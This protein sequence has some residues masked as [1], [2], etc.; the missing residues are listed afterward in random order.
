LE[1]GF[2]LNVPVG[3]FAGTYSTNLDV[4]DSNPEEVHKL[5]VETLVYSPYDIKIGAYNEKYDLYMTETTKY[6]TPGNSVIY[7][8]KVTNNGDYKDTASLHLYT[9]IF[10]KHESDGSTKTVFKLPS[11]S[12]SMMEDA[13]KSGEGVRWY[14]KSVQ[15][16]PGSFLTEP[17]IVDFSSDIDVEYT[18]EIRYHPTSSSDY[19]THVSLK[20]DPDQSAWVQ[21]KVD[22]PTDGVLDPIFFAVDVDSSGE[23]IRPNN[24]RVNMTLGCKYSDLAFDTTVGNK[25]L[26]ITGEK[27]DANPQLNFNAAIRNIGEIDATNIEVALYID[28]QFFDNRTVKK[29]VKSSPTDFEDIIIS[30]HWKPIQGSH[31][32]E[33]RIDPDNRI[34]ESNEENNVVSDS[35][36]IKHETVLDDISDEKEGGD[37]NLLFLILIIAIIIVI[38][39]TLIL[40]KRKKAVKEEMSTDLP[41][42]AQEQLGKTEVTSPEIIAPPVIAV[43]K[44]PK[45]PPSGVQQVESAAVET[46]QLN[47]PSIPKPVAALKPAPTPVP[48]TVPVPAAATD[49]PKQPTSSEQKIPTPVPVSVQQGAVAGDTTQPKPQVKPAQLDRDTSE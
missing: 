35:V 2:E 45:H 40:I 27:S 33:I 39:I 10:H 28:D 16:S 26:E 34:I 11:D 46:D 15:S 3:T 21:V 9:Y 6:I 19:A 7:D 22:Y 20:L 14:I 29:L 12:D 48:G 8:L 4:S 13:K 5:I 43:G 36:F 17:K 23:D 37:S 32:I 31:E 44:V 47:A 30:F 49:G 24:N 25:G 38:F 42:D 41:S 1:I 18:A